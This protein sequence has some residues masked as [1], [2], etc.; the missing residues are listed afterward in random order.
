MPE[1]LKIETMLKSICAV[2]CM[3]TNV[4]LQVSSMTTLKKSFWFQQRRS[5]KHVLASSQNLT[6]SHEVAFL[7]S[8]KA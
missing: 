5:C 1:Q 4:L 8:A 7:S 6:V 3:V 2:C